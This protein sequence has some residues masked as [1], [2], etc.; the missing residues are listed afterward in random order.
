[1]NDILKPYW[2]T[3]HE[4]RL[5]SHLRHLRYPDPHVRAIIAAYR[6]HKAARR[7]KRIKQ[8]MVYQLWDHILQAARSELGVVRTMKSQLRRDNFPTAGVE[9]KLRALEVYDAVI[10]ETIA[11]LR[12]VQKADEMTPSQFV[13]HL[14]KEGK[15]P[16]PNNGTHWTDYV[17]ASDRR[18]IEVM[19]D[20]LPHTGRGKRKVPF[21]R[22]ISSEESDKQRGKL[23]RTLVNEQE[24]A[25]REYAVSQNSFDR[26]ELEDRIAKMREAQYILDMLPSNIPLPAT[27]HGLLSMRDKV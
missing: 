19:F 7:A 23:V 20:S 6:D 11:K 18:K 14:R 8:T 24:A 16:I 9:A 25:E 13:E 1:V 10:A 12:K 27:W 22:R 3:M 15:R 17:K 4:S 5:L 21:E 2:L 26:E